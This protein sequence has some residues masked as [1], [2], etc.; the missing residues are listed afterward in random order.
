MRLEAK[1]QVYRSMTDEEFAFM[2]QHTR[3]RVEER[4]QA[5]N[6]ACSEILDAKAALQLA[7]ES[8]S[9]AERR[10][11]GLFTELNK[12]EASLDWM[13]ERRATAKGGIPDEDLMKPTNEEIEECV[14][15][16]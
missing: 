14:V 10:G 9:H 1:L 12:A 2:L 6:G 3:D 15:N 13:C 5:Y 4:R 8:L 16:L 11:R 7:Q